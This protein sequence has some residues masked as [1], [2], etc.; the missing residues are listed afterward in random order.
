M[1]L[2]SQSLKQPAAPKSDVT[3]GAVN[4]RRTVAKTS[5]ETLRVASGVKSMVSRAL[6]RSAF[7]KRMQLAFWNGKFRE[8]TIQADHDSWKD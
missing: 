5:C 7:C 3:V 2:T 8:T 4:N 6:R 1:R